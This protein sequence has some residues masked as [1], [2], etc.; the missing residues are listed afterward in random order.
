MSEVEGRTSQSYEDY[1]ADDPQPR[2]YPLTDDASGRPVYHGMAPCG[3]RFH[4]NE[5]HVIGAHEDG[6]FSLTPQPTPPSGMN[7]ILCRCCGW[8][9][10]VDHNRWRTV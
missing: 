4:F 10:Y 9:G 5:R 1:F 3:H 6:T 8:H 7:S 2:I